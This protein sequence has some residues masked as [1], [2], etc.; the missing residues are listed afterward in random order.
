M[1]ILLVAMKI[2]RKHRLSFYEWFNFQFT[3]KKEKEAY[4]SKTKDKDLE[5]FKIQVDNIILP[6]VTD[7]V[8][9]YW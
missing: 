8:P 3:V 4:F 5:I 9:M 6:W 2:V 1:L 7:G